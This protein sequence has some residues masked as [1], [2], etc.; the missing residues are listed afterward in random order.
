MAGMEGILKRDT[1]TAGALEKTDVDT[2]SGGALEKT[3]DSQAM[4]DQTE[5]KVVGGSETLTNGVQTQCIYKC[6]TGEARAMC[7]DGRG[8]SRLR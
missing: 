3:E 7:G 1:G 6:G 4:A 5:V 8:T 2:G